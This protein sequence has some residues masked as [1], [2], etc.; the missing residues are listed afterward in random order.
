[1]IGIAILFCTL[2]LLFLGYFDTKKELKFLSKGSREFVIRYKKLLGVIF[3]SLIALLI[4]I[5]WYS[6]DADIKYLK[7]G[8]NEILKE[9]RLTE[10]IKDS[11]IQ[12]YTARLEVQGEELFIAQ[13]KIKEL[14][15]QLDYYNKSTDEV[16][17]RS[18][19]LFL[20]KEF[21]EAIKV[22]E[23][24][25]ENATEKRLVSIYQLK[26]D[27]FV[28][29]AKF[30]KALPYTERLYYLQPS[31]YGKFDY[32]ELLFLNGEKLKSHNLFVEVHQEIQE[33]PKLID[34]L[35]L[36]KL[37]YYLGRTEEFYG[38]YEK[39]ISSYFRADTY[40]K[41]YYGGDRDYHTLTL[42]NAIGI[43]M[44]KAGKY[45]ASE[46][47]FTDLINNLQQFECLNNPCIAL[48][49]QAY[50]N[51]SNTI[52]VKEKNYELALIYLN[53]SEEFYGKIDPNSMGDDYLYQISG[54]KYNK[55]MTYI[56]L[57]KYDKARQLFKQ[58]LAEIP[59]NRGYLDSE[60]IQL[61]ILST[62]QLAHVYKQINS[63]VQAIKFFNKSL[64][65]INDYLKENP[66]SN[67][68]SLKDSIE[69]E[70][71]H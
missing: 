64:N 41:K 58:L 30:D 34:N 63:N 24:Y 53:Q 45:P 17:K 46:E 15:N 21:E 50:L 40:L 51:L 59:H 20:N 48:K 67:L 49:A 55:A 52:R 68:K 65:L 7:D 66:E 5:D 44:Y 11:I 25:T 8:Q 33:V 56:G 3:S 61:E 23:A 4:Y 54:L 19:T 1:M 14:L 10:E 18:Y 39:A 69:T 43:C 70:I 35:D 13:D 71:S 32:A 6:N 16:I 12:F 27:L 57:Q 31:L 22:L 60:Y 37:Y 38:M 62:F 29:Q 26:A 2:G 47:M 28:A 36:F 9:I 42:I